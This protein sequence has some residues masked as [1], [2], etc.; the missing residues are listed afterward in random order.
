MRKLINT[1]T[2]QEVFKSEN[3]HLLEKQKEYWAN[4]LNEEQEEL[5]KEERHYYSESDFVIA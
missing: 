2:G 3:I 5:P 4:L 1:V